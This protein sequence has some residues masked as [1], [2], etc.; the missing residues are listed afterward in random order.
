MVEGQWFGTPFE[1]ILKPLETVSQVDE[2]LA[3]DNEENPVSR[4]GRKLMR[5]SVE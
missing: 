3:F 2:I 5:T 4:S 1:P